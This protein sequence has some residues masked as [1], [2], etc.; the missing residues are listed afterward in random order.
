LPRLRSSAPRPRE[1]SFFLQAEDGIRDFHVTGVQTCALPICGRRS[2]QP[3]RANLSLQQLRSR[4]RPRHQCCSVP[5]AVSA[6]VPT[7]G[8]GDWY[9][10]FEQ[11]SP[12]EFHEDRKIVCRLDLIEEQSSILVLTPE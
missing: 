7:H 1:Y 12:E 10:G 11:S 3:G 5:G 4:G 2:A 9:Q 6:G 8:T